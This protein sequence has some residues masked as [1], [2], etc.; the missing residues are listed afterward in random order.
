MK[1][2][3]KKYYS[4]FYLSDA[5]TNTAK[6]QSYLDSLDAPTLNADIQSSLDQ[7]LA[8]NEIQ[9]VN[10][11]TLSGG[12]P[13]PDGFPIEYFKTFSSSLVPLLK[14]MYDETLESGC[15]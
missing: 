8:T 4:N 13:G 7:P 5:D 3:F 6:I 11:S 10:N 2:Q 15:L 1:S 9:A 14:S 12:T